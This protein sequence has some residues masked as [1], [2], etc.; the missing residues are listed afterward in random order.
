L[1]TDDDT[2]KV[3]R[4]KDG[5]LLTSFN[6]SYIAPILSEGVGGYLAVVGLVDL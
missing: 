5:T 3:Y 6:K 1:I 2:Y 4:T